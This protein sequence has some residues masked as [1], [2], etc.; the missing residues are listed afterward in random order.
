LLT[1]NSARLGLD[2]GAAHFVDVLV[3]GQTVK[4]VPVG[5]EA[6]R[7][8]EGPEQGVSL[9]ELSR[10]GGALDRGSGGDDEDGELSELHG[11]EVVEE[12]DVGGLG[13]GGVW[14]VEGGERWVWREVIE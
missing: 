7:E 10:N 9:L 11:E 12:E 6:S 3:T 5:I 2:D 13:L 4:R 1:V 8:A 14:E